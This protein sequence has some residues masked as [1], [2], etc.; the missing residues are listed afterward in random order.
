MSTRQ[1][2]ILL[3]MIL[4]FASVSFAK[5]VYVR[6]HYRRDGT[7]VQ[8]Y[9]RS[10]PNQYRWDNYSKDSGSNSYFS[11]YSSPYSRDYDKDGIYNQYDRDDNNNGVPD[12][13]EKN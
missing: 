6:G 12:D 5:D 3:L 8:P 10:T 1:R 9:I 4:S 7:Y 2:L 11:P 13:S